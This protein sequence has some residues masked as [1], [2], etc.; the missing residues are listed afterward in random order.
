MSYLRSLVKSGQDGLHPRARTDPPADPGL[1]GRAATG[2]RQLPPNDLALLYV[3]AVDECVD[4]EEIRN[5]PTKS[6]WRRGPNPQMVLHTPHSW[7]VLGRNPKRPPLV[8]GP[9]GPMQMN[10]AV[11][12]H[13]VI[14]GQMSPGVIGEQMCPGLIPELGHELFPNGR[15]INVLGRLRLEGG[16]ALKQVASADDAHELA[17][18]QHRNPLDP[19]PLN[20]SGDLGE[21]RGLLHADHT[22]C[23]DVPRGAAM[24]LGVVPRR[25]ALV[26]EQ[27]E[28][29]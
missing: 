25:Q 8:L 9:N 19:M 10:H 6:D 1:A 24:R 12:N 23:H 2:L 18:A 14:G 11:F 13:D 29:P 20:E 7:D 27:A 17:V 15:V 26:C 16:Q 5:G 4:L 3:G 28:P 22:C 21:G